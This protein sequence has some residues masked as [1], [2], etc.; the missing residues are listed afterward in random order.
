MTPTTDNPDEADYLEGVRKTLE[1]RGVWLRLSPKLVR[2]A[3]DRS[4]WVTDPRHFEVWLSLGARGD[5]IPTKSGRID[6]EALLNTRV[7]GAGYYV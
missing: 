6:R 7:L 4:R 2:D 3:D 5:T 1:T